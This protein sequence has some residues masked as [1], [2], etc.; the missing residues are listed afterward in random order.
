MKDF[1]RGKIDNSA[2][3]M[4]FPHNRFVK[5]NLQVKKKKRKRRKVDCKRH[6]LTTNLE[7]ILNAVVMINEAL[8]A[9]VKVDKT[10]LFHTTKQLYS[11]IELISP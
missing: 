5:I 10:K 6:V 1:I 3:S 11:L 7:K 9:A 4:V 8:P 2:K